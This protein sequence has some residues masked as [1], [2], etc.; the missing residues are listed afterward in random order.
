MHTSPSVV[1]DKV[2][3]SRGSASFAIEVSFTAMDFP[4]SLVL[5]PGPSRLSA[6]TSEVTTLRPALATASHSGDVNS[7]RTIRLGLPFDIAS[8]FVVKKKRRGRPMPLITSYFVC[9]RVESAGRF[10]CSD[11]LLALLVFPEIWI[12]VSDLAPL[13]ATSF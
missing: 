11:F 10:D 1:E 3:P 4:V 6:G 2:L 9:S 7:T 12:C 13:G 5:R 8:S